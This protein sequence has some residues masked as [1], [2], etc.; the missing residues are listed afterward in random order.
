MLYL[1]QERLEVKR[2]PPKVTESKNKQ[3]SIIRSE[4]KNVDGFDRV[5]CCIIKTTT[6]TCRNLVRAKVVT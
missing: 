3:K 1:L 6:P 5:S 2:N 4:E